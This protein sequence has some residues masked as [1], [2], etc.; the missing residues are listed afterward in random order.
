MLKQFILLIVLV[1]ALGWLT[2]DVYSQLADDINAFEPSVSQNGFEMLTNLENAA[3]RERPS[4]QDRI[5]EEQIHVY[6]DRVVIRIDNPEWSA[7]TDTNSMDPVLD[8]GANGIHIK[9]TKPSDIA[10]GDIVAYQPHGSEKTIIHRVI[11]IE[12]DD[13]GLYYILKGDNNPRED[14]G[15]IRFSQIKRVLVAIIY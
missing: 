11:S 9:P 2:H 14:P 8:Y 12:A 15:K 6:D 13:D 10:I 5:K 1:F 7:F 3:V 4:P